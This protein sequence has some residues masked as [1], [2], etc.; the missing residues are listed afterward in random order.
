MAATTESMKRVVFSRT[1]QHPLTLYPTAVGVLGAVGIGLFGPV[2][3]AVAA[4]LAGLGFG[5]G[6]LATQVLMR[7]E[8]I[9]AAHFREVHEKLRRRREA[10]IADLERR[11]G[12]SAVQDGPNGYGDQALKQFSMVQK[13]FATMQTLLATKF[14]PTELTYSRYFVAGEQAFLSVLDTLEG[15]VSRLQS[16]DAIEPG[17]YKERMQ[18]LKR[19]KPLAPADQD[20][21]RTLE[22]RMRLRASQLDAVN[23]LLT[24]N[25]NAIT[26]FD[27]VNAAIAE[28]K[29]VKAQTS[30]DLDSAMKELEALA[31]RA[32][33]LV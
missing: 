25:E 23:T 28:V 27:R 29:G 24:F 2:T 3:I 1:L 18:A 6:H 16:A 13:R 22:E 21:L 8:A 20:E 17:Y 5:L 14:E 19:E 26:E 12:E 30:V 33:K 32:K 9:A 7:P 11:L 10:T 15:I 4:T 31:Q